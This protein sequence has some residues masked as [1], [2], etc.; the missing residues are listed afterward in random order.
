MTKLAPGTNSLERIRTHAHLL[1]LRNRSTGV[2][3]STLLVANP[4]LYERFELCAQVRHVERLL[5]NDGW[6]LVHRSTAVPAQAV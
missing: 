5:A 3:T 4:D 1:R 6:C 2:A